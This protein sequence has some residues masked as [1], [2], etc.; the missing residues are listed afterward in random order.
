MNTQEIAKEINKIMNQ[1][2]SVFGLRVIDYSKSVGDVVEY[3][4]DWDFENDCQSSNHLDGC[5]TIALPCVY[6]DDDCLIEIE[7]IIKFCLKSYKGKNLLLVS[8][9]HSGFGDDHNELLIS[10][11]ICEGVWAL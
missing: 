5:S 3:S 4:F 2:S 7:T 9:E 1:K 10:D 11:A 8:G 6:D